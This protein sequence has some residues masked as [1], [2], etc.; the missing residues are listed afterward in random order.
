MKENHKR[1]IPLEW[2]DTAFLLI[3]VAF[4]LLITAIVT[5]WWSIKTATGGELVVNASAKIDYSLFQKVVASK[6]AVK[7]PLT[8]SFSDLADNQSDGD[9][10]A[11]LFNTT[12]SL[13]IVGF[14][15]TILALILIFVPKLRKHLFRYNALITLLAAI[16]LLIAT[17]NLAST[18]PSLVTKLSR[19]AH[20]K[21][22]IPSSWIS[23]TP[24]E[25]SSFWGSKKISGS[26]F[27]TWAKG[28]DFWIWGPS[29]GW[30]LTF[31]AALLLL[32]ATIVIYNA[33]KRKIV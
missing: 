4:I 7:T 19:V 21:F 16:L 17:L 15:L 2:Q 24:S 6:S 32:I 3:L 14:I 20:S 18:M 23:I 11:S 25:I 33:P 22:V 30:H 8:A 13:V 28:E 12:F 1:T 5:P 26:A 29:V 27:P 31:I 9:A 10:L